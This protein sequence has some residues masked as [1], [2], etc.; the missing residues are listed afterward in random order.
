ML[1]PFARQH[2]ECNR[3]GVIIQY[4]TE[5]RITGTEMIFTVKLIQLKHIERHR[6]RRLRRVPDPCVGRRVGEEEIEHLFGT[7][8]KVIVKH[9]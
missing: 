4:A 3:A 5:Q 1:P 9:L 8:Q 7:E 6:I 2:S